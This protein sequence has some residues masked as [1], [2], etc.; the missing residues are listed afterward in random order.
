[1]TRRTGAA[2]GYL[3]RWSEQINGVPIWGSVPADD[4]M[5]NKG[6]D[7]P[8]KIESQKAAGP[9]VTLHLFSHLCGEAP[10]MST[11]GE[12]LMADYLGVIAV[13][14]QMRLW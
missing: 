1:M 10:F 3:I 7:T 14:C 11:V 4:G 8:L 6:Q 13:A 5:V 12:P 9:R 2:G